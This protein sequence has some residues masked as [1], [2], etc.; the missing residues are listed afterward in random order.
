LSGKQII[1]STIL[2]K[3]VTSIAILAFAGREESGEHH[4]IPEWQAR[5]QNH[6]FWAAAP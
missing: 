6:S 1:S 2:D 4:V 3:A 5:I